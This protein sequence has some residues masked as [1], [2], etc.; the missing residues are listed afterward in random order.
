MDVSQSNDGGGVELR[1]RDVAFNL[2]VDGDITIEPITRWTAYGHGEP[3]TAIQI[4]SKTALPW[5]GSLS[6]EVL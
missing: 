1:G 3:V 6:L 2:S 5:T 4:I